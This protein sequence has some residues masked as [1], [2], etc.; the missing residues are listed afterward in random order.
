MS[1]WASPSFG[2]KCQIDLSLELVI[3]PPKSIDN[4][5]L[6]LHDTKKMMNEI[7][8]GSAKPPSSRH[9]VYYRFSTSP[10]GTTFFGDSRFGDT[11]KFLF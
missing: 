7:S 2:T 1:E 8:S 11:R 3:S 10:L 4:H 6:G 9:R 5:R